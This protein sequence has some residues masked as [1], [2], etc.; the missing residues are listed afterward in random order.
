M[1]SLASACAQPC[2]SLDYSFSA[3]LVFTYKYKIFQT[4]KWYYKH[5]GNLIVHCLFYLGIRLLIHSFSQSCDTRVRC[6]K[7]SNISSHVTLY[8]CWTETKVISS[9]EYYLHFNFSSFPRNKFIFKS[10]GVGER[11]RY[12]N[13]TFC[14]TL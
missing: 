11:R 7:F 9:L 10:H 8:P 4:W 5:A 14:N 6:V 3:F 12:E 13:K 2:P 1:R